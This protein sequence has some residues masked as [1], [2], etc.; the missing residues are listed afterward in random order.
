VTACRYNGPTQPR[1]LVGR[2]LDPDDQAPGT[3]HPDS[4]R[5][6]LPCPEDH[7]AVCGYEHA[8]D[9]HPLTCA[10][11]VGNIR[12]DLRAIPGLCVA[13]PHQAVDANGGRTAAAPIPGGESTVMIGP[14]VTA[15]GR[16]WYDEKKA[17]ATHKADEHHEDAT[18]PM[19]VLV[20]WEDAWRA[21]LGDTFAPGMGGR[22]TLR[23]ASSYLLDHLTSMAQKIAPPIDAFQEEI[24]ALRYHLE[25]VLGAGI[26]HQPGAPCT[27]CGQAL[28]RTSSKPS[29]CE[30]AKV[31]RRLDVSLNAMLVRYP[32][33]AVAHES[34]DQGGLRDTWQCLR[35]KRRYSDQEY[36]FAVGSDYISNAAALT[37]RELEWKTG[38]PATVIRVWGSRGL[39]TKRGR[40]DFG[41][42][43]YDVAGVEARVPEYEATMAAAAARAA[44][45]TVDK[46]AT[47]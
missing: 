36:Q 39:V 47:A 7:C 32:A 18:T 45:R 10:E 43:K 14:S 28:M 24:A 26:R 34:C 15:H 33:L 21:E 17:D 46:A 3:L 27:S 38:V 13:L 20:S 23:R 41:I 6:C 42:V 29:T 11:C 19:L 16:A 2:H 5:G 25:E 1:T 44:S 4:C 35:C 40:D 31:A 9:S 30:H 12:D 37:A 8:T 22:A